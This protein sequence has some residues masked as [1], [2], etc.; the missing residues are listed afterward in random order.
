MG[1]GASLAADAASEHTHSG[2]GGAVGRSTEPSV[3][4]TTSGEGTFARRTGSGDRS[5][6]SALGGK[7][8]AK[9]LEATTLPHGLAKHLS[10]LTGQALPPVQPDPAKLRQL[11]LRRKLLEEHGD[12][13]VSIVAILEYQVS[14]SAPLHVRFSYERSGPESASPDTQ[15]P[16]LLG[17]DCFPWRSRLG[18]R[19]CRR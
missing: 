14:V 2:M 19:E 9:I 15:A 6:G 13:L 5:E 3:H 11:E 4:R 1:C 16:T 10:T 17:R 8:S 7:Q 12:F 18:R